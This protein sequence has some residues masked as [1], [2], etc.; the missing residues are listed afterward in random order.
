MLEKNNKRTSAN[1]TPKSSKKDSIDLIYLSDNES[2]PGELKIPIQNKPK[3]KF[4]NAQQPDPMNIN[5]PIIDEELNIENL[6]Q[7]NKPS[8]SR[9]TY[10]KKRS[11][12]PQNKEIKKISTFEEERQKSAELPN[13]NKIKIVSNENN[14][15]PKVINFSQEIKM[16]FSAAFNNSPLK[17]NKDNNSFDDDFYKNNNQKLKND[18]KIYNY[19]MLWVSIISETCQK[20]TDDMK[21]PDSFNI[22]YI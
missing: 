11:N 2:D 1:N 3:S 20:I 5:I 22:L 9:S 21:I 7:I 19:L 14:F 12:F 13:N 10:E 18:I 17:I 6:E 15:M 8:R 16:S 4:F